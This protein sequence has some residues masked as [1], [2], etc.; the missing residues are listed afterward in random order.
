VYL[1]N[2]AVKH[3]KLDG[4]EDEREDMV[5][6]YIIKE[7]SCYERKFFCK[8]VGAGVPFGLSKKAHKLCSRLWA[9]LDIVPITLRR[10]QGHVSS[11]AQSSFNWDSKCVDEQADSMARKCIM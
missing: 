7:L 6:N 5:T 10:D 4:S 8:F 2:F 9:E 1:N 11:E 3:L